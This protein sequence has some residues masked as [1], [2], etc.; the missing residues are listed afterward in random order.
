MCGISGI[1]NFNATDAID[2]QLLERMT[3]AQ[4]HRGPDDHGYF[5]DGNVGLGH[6]RLSIIDLSGGGQPIFNEDGSVAIVFNGEVYNYADLT[7]QLVAQGHQF[8]TRSDTEAIVH[9]YEQH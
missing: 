7:T 2:R 4:A 8:K 3:D 6:R 5:I 1:V 9:S